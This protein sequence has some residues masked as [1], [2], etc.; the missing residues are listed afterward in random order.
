M[1]RRKRADHRRVVE[2]E[3]RHLHRHGGI[4]VLQAAHERRLI[5]GAEASRHLVRAVRSI[6][7]G[8][9]TVA[10]LMSVNGSSRSIERPPGLRADRRRQRGRAAAAAGH[11][12]QR[13]AG[14]RRRDDRARRRLRDRVGA[15]V[16]AHPREGRAVAR[17]AVIGHR[18]AGQA[19]RHRRRARARSPR[20][21]AAFWVPVMGRVLGALRVPPVSASARIDAPSATTSSGGRLVSGSR[22]K[23]DDTRWRTEGM[24]VLPPT[25]ITAVRSVG[26]SP[27]SLSASEHTS[28]VRETKGAES[29]SSSVRESPWA[30]FT[31]CPLARVMSRRDAG[32]LA[33]RELALRGLGGVAQHVVDHPVLQR[34][35]LGGALKGLEQ[36]V[37]DGDVDVVAAEEGV[38]RRR[39]HLEDVARQLEQ[40]DVEGAAAEVV[41]ADLLA[42]AAPVAVGERRRGGL[43]EDAHHLELGD[44]PGHL[45]AR[46]LQLV[47]VRGHGDHAPLD[48]VLEPHLRDALAPRAAPWRRALA[49]RGRR[50]GSTRSPSCRRPPSGRRACAIGRDAPPRS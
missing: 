49:A 36:R 35:D 3:G 15:G 32:G 34:V 13:V 11:A 37:G 31:G 46:P 42:G 48:L 2:V 43:V 33:R 38:A 47:E 45:G 21:A 28:K 9:I 39:E 41:D 22:P 25:R 27:A 30:N 17:A 1:A 4:G 12:A 6:G 20:A 19:R 40:R 50:R 24:R 10:L 29:R 8:C 18:R 26:R 16:V 23:N 7:D 44:A 5:E 14:H